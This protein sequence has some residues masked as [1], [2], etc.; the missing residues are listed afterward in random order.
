MQ[1]MNISL[2]DQMKEYVDEHV[3]AGR[4]SSVSEFVRN[5]IRA[6]QKRKAEEQL[7]SLLLASMK[8]GEASNMSRQDWEAIRREALNRLEVL[9]SRGGA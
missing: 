3:R 9:K 4:Y 5:L 6:D 1:T 7:E 2:P 8:S